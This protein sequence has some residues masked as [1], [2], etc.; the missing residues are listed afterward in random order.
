MLCFCFRWLPNTL[1]YT[2]QPEAAPS[3]CLT[4]TGKPIFDAV[5]SLG[6]CN[7][8]EAVTV[9]ICVTA[10]QYRATGLPRTRHSKH[11]ASQKY[12]VGPVENRPGRQQSRG[13]PAWKRSHENR[14]IEVEV[15]A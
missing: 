4:K 7:A 9:I 8:H 15:K 12:K 14:G 5:L 1:L 13:V 3:Q 6:G 2:I 11:K 10:G